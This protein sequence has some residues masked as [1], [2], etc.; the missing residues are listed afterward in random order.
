MKLW[1][2]F[3][4]LVLSNVVNHGPKIKER[5]FSWQVD[6]GE[7][8]KRME[9]AGILMT[10][11]STPSSSNSRRID[12]YYDFNSPVLPHRGNRCF[13]RHNG[14][15]SSTSL[16]FRHALRLLQ[17]LGALWAAPLALLPVPSP[18]HRGPWADRWH[19]RRV[20]RQQTTDPDGGA[21]G[22]HHGNRFVVKQ[23][24]C[25][26]EVFRNPKVSEWVGWMGEWAGWVGGW[27]VLGEW[28][29]GLHWSSGLSGWV[30][31]SGWVGWLSGWVWCW[32][33]YFFTK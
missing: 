7:S 26:Y 22:D 1:C 14:P 19:W 28:V 3:V 32:L 12:V 20:N 11:S 33:F 9:A 29:G 25:K 2:F 30:G 31:C 27:A 5:H 6:G 21:S 13:P 24:Y 4:F 8:S 17:Q 23:D 10:P 16:L 15:T 18:T